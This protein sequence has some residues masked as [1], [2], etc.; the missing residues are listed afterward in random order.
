MT[1]IAL[2]FLMNPSRFFAEIISYKNEKIFLA[3]LGVCSLILSICE[4]KSFYGDMDNKIITIIVLLFI[5]LIKWPLIFYLI[6]FLIG[7]FFNSR[8]KR[9]F[10][11]L[12]FRVILYSLAPILLV[13]LLNIFYPNSKF[14]SIC[15]IVFSVWSFVMFTIGYLYIKRNSSV[16][17]M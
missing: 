4:L 11:E 1:K 9:H 17:K 5:G 7:K 16:I 12:L 2:N 13:G 3:Y 6:A 14:V 15:S 10:T 8:P